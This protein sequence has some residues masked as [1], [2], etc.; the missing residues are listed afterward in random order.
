MGNMLSNFASGL[1]Q[2][3]NDSYMNNNNN[4]NN[5][6]NY[7]NNNN[8]NNINTLECL[9]VP[10]QNDPA[11][12]CLFLAR[13]LHAR[14]HISCVNLAVLLQKQ[15]SWKQNVRFLTNFLQE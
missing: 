7:N 12:S 14:I 3:N 4:N 13:N 9:K 5:N 8:N 6:N 2:E 11:R 1:K 15:D 10:R